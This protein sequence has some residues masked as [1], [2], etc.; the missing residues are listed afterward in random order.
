MK[1]ETIDINAHLVDE[2]GYA[3]R[4]LSPMA[5]GLEGSRILAIADEIRAMLAAGE[6]VCNL[7]VGDF[8]PSQFRIPTSLKDDIVA[9]NWDSIVFDVGTD[10][11][12]RVPTLE[13]LRGTE[14]HVGNVLDDVDTVL[15]L[16]AELGA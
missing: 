7:T 11:L 1:R 13:P 5:R 6:S 10:P 9:A 16:L 2:P 8:K 12:R 3:E 15:E 4:A 14:A